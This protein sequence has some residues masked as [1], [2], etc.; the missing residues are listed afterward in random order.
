MD[1]PPHWGQSLLVVFMRVPA[2]LERYRYR[3]VVVPG[4]VESGRDPRF[5]AWFST[6]SPIL[7]GLHRERN[8]LL[9]MRLV[10]SSLLVACMAKLVWAIGARRGAAAVK[11][12]ALWS[13]CSTRV[14]RP[15]NRG[16]RAC[17]FP[18][19]GRT[20]GPSLLSGCFQ[21]FRERQV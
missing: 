15:M 7:V 2:L 17:F 9:A 4:G 8:S 11:Q 3:V 18:A 1:R 6:L 14:A 20:V 12:P 19:L 16:I 21:V 13:D 10:L 5:A